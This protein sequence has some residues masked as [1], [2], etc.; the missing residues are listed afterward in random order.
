MGEAGRDGGGIERVKSYILVF[1]TASSC[2]MFAVGLRLINSEHAVEGGD[3]AGKG[4]GASESGGDD[5]D[6]MDV[7]VGDGDGD[8]D[9]G[10]DGDGDGGDDGDDD[11][12]GGRR[13]DEGPRFWGS[14]LDER[15]AGPDRQS[16]VISITFFPSPPK[17][18]PD[19][20]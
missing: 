15:R 17:Y 6:D 5:K 11:G 18:T 16:L 19:K 1:A 13:V 2:L 20:R 8:G 4:L 14:D 3:S 7:E 9:G 12:N 10:G